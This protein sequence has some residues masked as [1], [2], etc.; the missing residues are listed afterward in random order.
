MT[1]EYYNGG[2]FPTTG[3]AAT[4]ASMR[5]ELASVTVGFD[6]LP[7]LTGNGSKFVK[8]NAGGTALEA[9]SV[10]VGTGDVVGPSASVASE[11]ALFDGTTGKLIKRATTTG[12]LKATSGVLAAAVSNTD[13]QAVISATG[14]LKGAGSGSISAATANTDY[15]TSTGAD[16]QF[17]RWMFKDTGYTYLDKGNSGTTTQTLDYTAGS[18]QKITVTGAHTIATSNW[19]PSGN[20]GELLLEL[21]NGASS[22]IT[23]PTINWIKSDGTTTTTFS[24]NGVT[25]QTS[26]TDWI[27]LW[28]RDAGTTIYGKVVR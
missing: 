13:Y 4:S 10:T 28:S 3:S 22:T 1:N 27:L 17:T 23:W 14:L 16:G 7:V 19:P 20:L 21:V 8:V 6:K 24:S 11:L 2:T 26:G 15:V 5:S 18:H 25:L 9:V 12:L